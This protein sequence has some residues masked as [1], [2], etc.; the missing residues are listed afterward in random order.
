MARRGPVRGPSYPCKGCNERYRRHGSVASVQLARRL[1]DAVLLII[2]RSW[3]RAPPAPPAAWASTPGG[4]TDVDDGYCAA[5]VLAVSDAGSPVAGVAEHHA[6]RHAFAGDGGDAAHGA[7]QPPI[8]EL[9][10]PGQVRPCPAVGVV[11]CCG[12]VDSS[13]TAWMWRG[14]AVLQSE[15]SS[16][17]PPKTPAIASARRR[18]PEHVQAGWRPGLSRTL[19][20]PSARWSKFL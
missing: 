15:S 13:Q 5:Q 6:V 1:Q 16:A 7:G 3:V 19:V 9:Q 10:G 17:H 20:H 12:Q 2:R 18:C 11:P 4:L 14:P 8:V